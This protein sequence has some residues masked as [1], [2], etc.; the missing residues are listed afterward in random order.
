MRIKQQEDV[1]HYALRDILQSI[2]L[3]DAKKF[4]Q[5]DNMQTQ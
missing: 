5:M 1:Y 4:A 3:K 2:Q